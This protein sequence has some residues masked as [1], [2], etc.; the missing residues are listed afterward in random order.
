MLKLYI[1]DECQGPSMLPGVTRAHNTR[2]RPKFTNTPAHAYREGCRPDKK[3]TRQQD[4]RR[5]RGTRIADAKEGTPQRDSVCVWYCTT[6]DALGPELEVYGRAASARREWA[7]DYFTA[8]RTEKVRGHANGSTRITCQRTMRHC[9]NTLLYRAVT[10]IVRQ[11]SLHGMTNLGGFSQSSFLSVRPR[12]SILSL[13]NL[14]QCICHDT[15]CTHVK[16]SLHSRWNVISIFPEFIWPWRR[17]RT[18][19][20][21]VE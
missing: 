14:V 4:K 6:W 3:E 2:H 16:R 15:S 11:R 13:D 7:S 21:D 19:R 12:N 18:N 20:G 1:I 5:S 9:G 10:S 8:L 17:T